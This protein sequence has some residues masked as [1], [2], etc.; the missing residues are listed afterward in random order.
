[1]DSYTVDHVMD[2]AFV[3]M[4]TGAPNQKVEVRLD[5]GHT[6]VMSSRLAILHGLLWYP[7]RKLNIPVTRSEVY[8]IK[9]V[10]TDTISKIQT[11][12]YNLHI[13]Y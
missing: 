1:M 4:M 2:Q 13:R 11:I 7:Y 5:D 3:T 12:Q 9:S 8:N 6:E 10:S